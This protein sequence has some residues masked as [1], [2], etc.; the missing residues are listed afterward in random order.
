MNVHVMSA[1]NHARMA[2][3]SAE[4]GRWADA[5]VMVNRADSSLWRARDAGADSEEL[6]AVTE[7]V[8]RAY[9]MARR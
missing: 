3:N 6:E 9:R 1:R 4:G 5:L 8:E 2:L 7:M